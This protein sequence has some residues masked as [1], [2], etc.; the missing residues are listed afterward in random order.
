[1]PPSRPTGDGANGEWSIGPVT[2]ATSA[3]MRST[4]SRSTSGEQPKLMRTCPLPSSPNSGPKCSA[5]FA[6]RRIFTAGLSPQ[7]SAERSTH[8]RKPASGIR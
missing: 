8:A 7:P 5:T 2:V 1:M 6:S 3:P 4:A